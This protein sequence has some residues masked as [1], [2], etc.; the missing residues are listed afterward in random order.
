MNNLGLHNNL[1][2]N[3]MNNLCLNNVSNFLVK[4][5]RWNG[6]PNIT[7]VLEKSNDL[8]HSTGLVCFHSP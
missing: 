5:F 1:H 6:Q 2:V 4:A 3:T 7:P 8:N